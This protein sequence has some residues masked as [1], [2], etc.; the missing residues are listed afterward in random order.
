METAHRFLQ[1]DCQ[2]AERALPVLVLQLFV[3]REQLSGHVSYMF[4]QV[5]DSPGDRVP[6][7]AVEHQHR[8][9]QDTNKQQQVD[10]SL[11]NEPHWSSP[12]VGGNLLD[13]KMVP[14]PLC[15][16]IPRLPDPLD[17]CQLC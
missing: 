14:S 2:R 8:D 9:A 16:D 3:V 17:G 13:E 12:L 7:L 1:L 6:P 10:D 5:P 11:E 15:I 4:E